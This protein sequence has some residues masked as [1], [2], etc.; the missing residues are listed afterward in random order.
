VPLAGVHVLL[1]RPTAPDAECIARFTAAGASV[2]G[3]ALT[4]FASIGTA[5]EVARVIANPPPN[6][7]LLLSSAHGA[8]VLGERLA[9]LKCNPERVGLSVGCVGPATA[10]AWRAGGGRVAWVAERTSGEGVAAALM[11]HVQL[12]GRPLGRVVHATAV[13]PHPSLAAALARTQVEVVHFALYA[14]MP[15]A[16]AGVRLRAELVRVQA[17]GWQPALVFAAPS[18]VR[19]AATGLGADAAALLAGA[20]RCAIGASTASALRAAGLGVSATAA[21]ATMAS[22]VEALTA[23]RFANHA[24]R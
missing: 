1:L 9:E 17:S 16:D 5:T 22:V 20:C 3:L 7:W 14:T 12:A 4:E 2:S 15:V 21:S 23:W 6:S 10:T 19:A 8:R 18:T 11:T 24:A 13:E